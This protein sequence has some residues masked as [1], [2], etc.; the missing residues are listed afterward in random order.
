MV[1]LKYFFQFIIIVFFFSLFKL[2]GL[3]ISRIVSG[4]IF[5]IIGPIFR[6]N[7]IADQNLQ[8]AIPN[9]DQIKRK[10]IIKNMW[11][12][13]GKIFSEY[14]FIKKFRS[15]EKFSK[16]V[17]IKNQEILNDIINQNEPVIFISGHFSNFEL[18]AMQL[19]RIGVDLAVIYRPLNN[20][21]L[22]P[23]MEKIRKKYICKIQ[24]KKGISGTKELLK[25]YKD[26]KSIALMIDQRVS[27]G[28]KIKLFNNDAFTTTIPAQFFRK[29]STKIVPIYIER[30]PNDVF[31]MKIIQPIKFNKNDSIEFITLKLNEV[32]EK[33]ILKNPD[34]WIWT[35][36]R[37]K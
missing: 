19:E 35:H 28:I 3:K 29:F 31:V 23:I 11:I 2:L 26:K 33:M 10:F 20:I 9:L 34:Q 17:E 18:M 13:Y 1:K 15:S 21:F 37:W 36:N 24:V 22:N 12:N 32:L 25:L 6:S 7:K 27:E 8:I 4:F 5:S 16:K 14:M 30:M